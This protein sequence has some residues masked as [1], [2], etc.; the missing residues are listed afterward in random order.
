MKDMPRSLAPLPKGYSRLFNQTSLG[1]SSSWCQSSGS[2]VH[3]SAGSTSSSSSSSL[4]C[5]T[6]GHFFGTGANCFAAR[7]RLTDGGGSAG[8]G[9]FHGRT[10]CCGGLHGRAFCCGGLRV[11]AFGGCISAGPAFASFSTN[12]FFVAPVQV[13]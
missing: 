1:C 13:E 11:F 2:C 9:G 6:R 8:S 5:S 3:S 7:G 4:G 12:F 10:F